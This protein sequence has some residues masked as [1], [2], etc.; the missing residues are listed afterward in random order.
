M[1]VGGPLAGIGDID[2]AGLD[3][4]YGASVPGW[5]AALLAPDPKERR[6][7]SNSL[8]DGGDV[9]TA[10]LQA[11][12]FLWALAA[13]QATPDRGKIVDLVGAIAVADGRYLDLFDR[14]DV[15]AL[16][17]D[18]AAWERGD[19]DDVVRRREEWVAT[20]PAERA[21]VRR[22]L[23]GMAVQPPQTKRQILNA[24]AAYDAVKAGAPVLWALL[25][26]PDEDVRALSAYVLRLFPERAENIASALA[27]LL[28]AEQAP[29]VLATA[30]ITSWALGVAGSLADRISGF[31]DHPHEVVKLA[32]AAVLARQPGVN[33]LALGELLARAA[34]PLLNLDPD[35]I[36]R[37]WEYDQE[38]AWKVLND[39]DVGVL[40]EYGEPAVLDA[41][42]QCTSY[43][44]NDAVRVA[45]S[46]TFGPA[47][48]PCPPYD[49]LTSSQQRVIDILVDVDDEQWKYP[50]GFVA[51]V[52][53]WGLPDSRD[54][55]KRYAGIP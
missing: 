23:L 30:M 26:D 27:D 22:L 12:P 50:F 14:F 15:V 17:R 25:A 54:D 6:K 28:S 49:Q 1:T 10:T 18:A 21:D 35:R 20:A 46:L 37:Y 40:H 44:H 7:A 38:Y 53:E 3:D 2:W 42:S 33:P 55:L 48:L 24:L 47:S 9:L 31:L 39:I 11:I 19:H 36:V 52:R 32:A 51:V 41:V 4:G 13:D 8:H 43:M 45:L 16:R 34:R 5:L 29:A